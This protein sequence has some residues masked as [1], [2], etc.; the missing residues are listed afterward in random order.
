MA[1]RSVNELAGIWEQM[2]DIV[3]KYDIKIL[4]P[5]VSRR[6]PIMPQ[7]SDLLQIV[8][9]PT[10]LSSSN[11]IVTRHKD[12][13]QKLTFMKAKNRKPSHNYDVVVFKYDNNN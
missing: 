10:L 8:D 1:N 5:P 4:P 3:G 6:T 2:R 12:A 7:N 9:Y 11:I 13:P